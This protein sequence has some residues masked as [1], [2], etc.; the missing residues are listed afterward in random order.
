MGLALAIADAVALRRIESSADWDRHLSYLE[1]GTRAW[2][3]HRELPFW[4]PFPCGGLPLLAHPESSVWS[5]FYGASLLLSP[6]AYLRCYVSVHQL[7]AVSGMWFLATRF[8]RRGGHDFRAAPLA[9][10]LFAAS[11]V[12]PLHLAEGHL[13]WV[14]AA[15]LPWILLFFE[16]AQDE[17]RRHRAFLAGMGLAIMIGEGATYP[18]THA[19]MFIVLY[20]IV[21]A[22]QARRS[23]PLLVA[24]LTLAA[25]TCF[26]GPKLLPMFEF[27]ARRPR[28][29]PSDEI[30]PVVGLLQSLVSRQQMSFRHEPWMT[31]GWHEYGHYVGL[32]GLG[33]AALGA[34]AGGRRARALAV[35]ALVFLVLAAGHFASWAPWT[36][37][38]NLPGLRS[39]HVPTRFLLV[40]L[41]VIALLA[42]HGLAVLGTTLSKRR[43]GWIFLAAILFVA[44]DIFYV[45]QG[46]LKP[47]QCMS[48]VQWSPGEI[49]RE[50]ILS[51]QQAPPDMVCHD[52]L[53]GSCG[54]SNTATAARAGVALI[55]VNEPLCP[56]A[57]STEYSGRLPGLVSATDPAYRGEAWLDPP[58]GS[59]R[60]VRS[61]SNAVSIAV[62]ASEACTLVLN[63]NADPGW[64]VA[65]MALG[66]PFADAQQRL[67][68]QVPAG[69]YTVTL[70][71]RPPGL[72][73]G[74]VLFFASLAGLVMLWSRERRSVF[75]ATRGHRVCGAWHAR[76]RRGTERR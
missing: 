3:A 69:T 25:A 49:R 7:I 45:R 11:T 13:E 16:Q 48:P 72:L 74:L 32:V 40:A 17:R 38:H 75:L 14:P 70:H 12:F 55:D 50:P 76:A 65:T 41:L 66:R 2:L 27:L 4:N 29:M 59:A 9:V 15:F 42:A 43:R 73:W 23:R 28:L 51:L 37:L 52:L 24:A 39:Q 10:C 62:D 35:V 54:C 6:V 26:A 21:L 8:L 20:A 71:Y 18:A 56:R 58:A 33:L 46:I 67:A 19:A 61:S 68:L 30:T 31:W 64:S 5:P 63:R 57:D 36:L 47:A 22:C 1:A 34:M 44:V 60:M 53:G